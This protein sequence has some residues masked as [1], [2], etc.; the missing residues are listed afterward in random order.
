MGCVITLQPN[1]QIG[2][3]RSFFSLSLFCIYVC[4]FVFLFVMVRGMEG[5]YKEAFGLRE[6]S[7]RVQHEVSSRT[8]NYLS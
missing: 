1:N 7:T 5:K 8:V 3:T 2:T 6:L 4:V